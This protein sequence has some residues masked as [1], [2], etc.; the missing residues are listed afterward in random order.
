MQSSIPGQQ[1]M[2]SQITNDMRIYME[3][4]RQQ[5]QQRYLQQQQQRQQHQSQPNNH[6][7]ASSPPSSSNLN[8]TSQINSAAVLAN[9]QATNGI[10]SPAHN[11]GSGALSGTSVSPRLAN[12]MQAQGLSSGMV[13]AVNTISRE[14]KLRHPQASP[15]QVSKMTTDSLNQYRMSHSQAAMAAAVGNSASNN[16]NT[17]LQVPMQQQAMMNGVSSSPMMNPAMYTQMMRSQ[18]PAPPN[19]NGSSSVNGTRPP[20]RSATPLVHRNSNGPVGPSQSPR[21]PRA[22]MAGVQ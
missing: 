13:P 1:R 15:E 7:G 18:Q 21:P 5:E 4:N 2:Q 14:I 8:G 22:Q 20:S 10:S 19:R 16:L 9:F 12:P 17:G 3:A 6:N 11:G